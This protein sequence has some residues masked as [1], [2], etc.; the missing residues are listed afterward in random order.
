MEHKT[1]RSTRIAM[2]VIAFVMAAGFIG[3]YFLIFIQNNQN[4]Q[5]NQQTTN[6]TQNSQQGQVDPTAYKVSG[7]VAALQTVDL[8]VGTGTEAKAGDLVTI[9]YKGTLAQTGVKFDSSYD[10]GEPIT[11][12][13]TDFI[14]GWQQGIPGMKVGGKRRLI[15]PASLGYGSQA[16]SSIPANS[17]LV[18]EVELLGVNPANATDQCA[19]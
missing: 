9:H 2:W 13:L 14:Q 11:C 19:G 10:K 17:D 3:S 1:K 16:M 12:K 5:T 18:F 8:T 7:K 15:I 4:S 6:T